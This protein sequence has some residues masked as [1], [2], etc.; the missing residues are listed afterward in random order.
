MQD[1]VR[2]GLISSVNRA[3]GTARV[4]YP[5]REATTAELPLFSGWGETAFP[6]PGE[7]VAVIHLSNDTSS[8]IIL[9]R[10]YDETALPQ[11]GVDYWK[12]LGKKAYVKEQGD[13]L[14]LYAGDLVLE[15]SNGRMTLAEIL[16]LKAR[17]EAL[18]QRGE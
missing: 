9:G 12:Q 4:Y 3:A 10:F 15:D 5:D 16:N 7:Q 8:G 2:V 11:A 13:Q 17:I 6:E 14:E 1:I 18:E